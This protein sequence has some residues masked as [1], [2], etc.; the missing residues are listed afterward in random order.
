MSSLKI[1]FVQTPKLYKVF[2]VFFSFGKNKG[3]YATIGYIEVT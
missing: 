3:V 2:F 1:S